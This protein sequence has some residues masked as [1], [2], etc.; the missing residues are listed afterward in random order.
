M[1]T[2]TSLCF[3]S[4][5]SFQKFILTC[6]PA[7][8]PLCGAHTPALWWK[9]KSGAG[10]L[11]FFQ[12]HVGTER[13]TCAFVFLSMWSKI[14]CPMTQLLDTKSYTVDIITFDPQVFITIWGTWTLI[15]KKYRNIHLLGRCRVFSPHYTVGMFTVALLTVAQSWVTT[16]S[17]KL[18]LSA[19]LQQY[20]GGKNKNLS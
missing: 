10:A 13:E 1:R 15:N 4:V 19:F 17:A 2:V 18:L 8:R 12:L 16:V 20:S 3:H 7:C 11:A 9:W 5:K 6:S 14:K